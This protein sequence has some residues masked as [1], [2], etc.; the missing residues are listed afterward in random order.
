V[1]YAVGPFFTLGIIIGAVIDHNLYHQFAALLHPQQP[2]GHLFL[3]PEASLNHIKSR[4][5]FFQQSRS[6]AAVIMFGDSITEFGGDWSELLDTSALNRGIA[7]DTTEGMLSRLD[8]VIERKPKIVAVM[9]GINDVR[10]GVPVDLVAA[11]IEQILTKLKAANVRPVMQSTLPTA[12][13]L[14]EPHTNVAVI[15]LNGALSQWCA[16]QDVPFL[17][18]NAFLAPEGVLDPSMTLDDIHLNDAGYL[19]WRDVLAPLLHHLLNS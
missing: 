10:M 14:G 16:S 1:K 2:A 3:L 13:Q 8:E 12:S 7:S 4:T 15:S 5:A 19:R 18:L 9:A 6:E 17:D 11:H